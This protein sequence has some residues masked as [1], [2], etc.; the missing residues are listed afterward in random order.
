M[1]TTVHEPPKIEERRD[2]SRLANQFRQW[3]PAELGPG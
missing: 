1:A 3:R 2:P